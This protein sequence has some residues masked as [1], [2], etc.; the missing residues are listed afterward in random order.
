[1]RKTWQR[2]IL[3]LFLL[4]TLLASSAAPTWAAP[5]PATLSAPDLETQT[6]AVD[7]ALAWMLTQIADDGSFPSG[8]DTTGMTID[9]LFAGLAAGQ[10]VAQ[11]TSASGD[12]SPLDY[13]A[14]QVTAYCINAGKA[15]KLLA[16]VTAAGLDPRSFAGDDLVARVLAYNTHNDGVMDALAPNQAW[17]IMGLAAAREPLPDGA[18]G[19]L[20]ALQ[21]ADGGW[22]SGY[23]ED[24]DTTSL[25]LQALIAGGV[26]SDAAAITNGLAY[27]KAAQ[28]ATGGFTGWG[29]DVSLN[30]TAFCLQAIIAAGQN[31]L[32]AA[33]LAGGRSAFD[34]L[35]GAQ[36]AEGA[37]P[38]W[39]GAPDVMTTA[40]AVPAILGKPFPLAGT[41]P[42]LQDALAWL[43][44]QQQADG[45]FGIGALGVSI[46]SQALLALAA[47]GEDP[48]QWKVGNGPSL[49][50]YMTSQVGA[51]NDVGVAGRTATAL[52]MLGLDPRAFGGRDLIAYIRSCYNSSTGAFDLHGNIWNHCLALW[53]MAAA[54]EPISPQ[55]IAW[56]RAQQNSDG[57]WGWA[58]GM[59]SDSNST[60]LALQSL[61][62][63]GDAP[64]AA[65]IAYLKTVQMDDGGFAYEVNDDMATDA[66]STATT[67]LGLLMV[68]DPL[69]GW[70]WARTAVVNETPT[71]TVN[72]PMDSLLA[73]QTA[74]G[75]F[76]W[77]ADGSDNLLATVQAVPALAKAK[78][79]RKTGLYGAY[80][81]LLF[82]VQSAY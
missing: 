10:D 9:A 29:S 20:L 35:V 53:G 73:M 49:L 57:G 50:E 23:G 43:R 16:V 22:D 42:A 71:L 52:D 74:N 13:L 28:V 39:D 17:A 69:S 54:N 68:D 80:I 65:G 55:A 2:P 41:V 66:N 64:H 75:G 30:T 34:D 51:I 45:G 62:A 11:W 63:Y 40:Q 72:K 21:Q 76:R 33:W 18:V 79:P 77:M 46:S 25:A 59:D 70:S 67:L 61:A 1:M 48:A 15:G 38:G 56:L 78:L 3:S 26:A 27:L 36:L 60:A 4:L 5:T 32:A 82:S 58:A 14:S 37:F 44:T 81:P 7:R 31:P 19:A 8:W 6:S 12:S 24:P 47:V